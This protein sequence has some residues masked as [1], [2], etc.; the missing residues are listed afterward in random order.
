MKRFLTAVAL[1]AVMLWVPVDGV[2]QEPNFTRED[3]GSVFRDRDVEPR[4]WRLVGFDLDGEAQFR[5][6][7]GKWTLKT[8]EDEGQGTS[9]DIT[10]FEEFT[11]L[12]SLL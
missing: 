3:I 9:R 1:A 8:D 4:W 10:D 11:V 5:R 7:G 2:A 12:R 6:W